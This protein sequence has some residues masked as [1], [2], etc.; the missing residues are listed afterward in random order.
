M[1]IVQ[2]SLLDL[3]QVSHYTRNAKRMLEECT[4]D[5]TN[6]GLEDVRLVVYKGNKAMELY[7]EFGFE[8]Y[9][10]VMHKKL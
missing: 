9:R 10:V 8:E 5:F 7:E 3:E 1:E 2:A 4:R 6:Q